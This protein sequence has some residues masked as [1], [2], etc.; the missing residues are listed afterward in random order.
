MELSFIPGSPINP[1]SYIFLLSFSC[2]VW[3]TGQYK[4][5]I[6]S[7]IKFQQLLA[8]MYHCLS[9]NFE[10]HDFLCSW[11]STACQSILTSSAIPTRG[12]N[13]GQESD[14]SY[15]AVNGSWLFILP[16]KRKDILPS[17]MHHINN[18]IQY[19]WK[20]LKYTDWL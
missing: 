4:T 6:G 9:T 13:L 2:S 10:I 20:F 14:S 11:V 3:F 5:H 12:Q 15:K 1:S 16:S 7:L 8:S 17:Q 18:G 19:I